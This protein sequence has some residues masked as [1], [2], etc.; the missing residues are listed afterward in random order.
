LSPIKPLISRQ[1]DVQHQR[2]AED[3]G[4]EGRQQGAAKTAR[5]PPAV[6]DT[7]P[8]AGQTPWVAA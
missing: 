7:N 1:V 2:D 6:A 4:G 3:R 8:E 5:L